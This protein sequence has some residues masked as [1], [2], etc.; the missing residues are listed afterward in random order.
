MNRPAATALYGAVSSSFLAALSVLMVGLWARWMAVSCHDISPSSVPVGAFRVRSVAAAVDRQATLPAG[1]PVLF[2]LP[3]SAGFSSR[4]TP[5]GRSSDVVTAP[6]GPLPLLDRPP[7][8]QGGA[9]R[10]PVDGASL[11]LDVEPAERVFNGVV[12]G[13]SFALRVFWPDGAPRVRSGLPGAGELAAYLG[14]KPWELGAVVAFDA[15]GE[16]SHV[17]LER[18]TMSRERNEQVG[19][20]LHRLRIDPPEG[21]PSRVRLVLRYEQEAAPRRA[22]P[23]LE[24]P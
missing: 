5:V 18:P 2:S 8:R 15:G 19:R 24:I 1:S 10:S 12:A 11:A 6:A 17:F 14:D 4:P 23:I 9:A 21:Q 3:T 16:A 20:A 7:A 22:G 13:T